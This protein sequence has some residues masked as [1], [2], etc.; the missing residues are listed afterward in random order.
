[1]T[2]QQTDEER[3]GNR[4]VLRIRGEALAWSQKSA[5]NRQA[6]LTEYHRRADSGEMLDIAWKRAL[7]V[8]YKRRK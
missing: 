7:W 1:M 6:V 5:A 8:A 4:E 2:D 3:A